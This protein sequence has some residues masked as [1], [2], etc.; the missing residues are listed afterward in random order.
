M[1]NRRVS[2]SKYVKISYV[3]I[4]KTINLIYTFEIDK[5][6]YENQIPLHIH[7]F[8]RR[9]VLISQCARKLFL[10]PLASHKR[11]YQLTNCAID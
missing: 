3:V 10:P 11:F 1:K 8:A 4:S 2:K 9:N 7:K 5:F 6:H